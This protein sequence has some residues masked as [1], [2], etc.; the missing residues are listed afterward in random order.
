MCKHRRYPPPA[1]SRRCLFVASIR[2]VRKIIFESGRHATNKL[3][4]SCEKT[5]TG[6]RVRP[7]QQSTKPKM[8]R[9]II[10]TATVCTLPKK[11]FNPPPPAC[12]DLA[13]VCVTTVTTSNRPHVQG[14]SRRS[15]RDRSLGRLPLGRVPRARVG[16]GGPE[17]R[18]RRLYLHLG[19]R[20][21]RPAKPGGRPGPEGGAAGVRAGR[22]AG[23]LPL[24]GRLPR[25]A[26][27]GGGQEARQG[28]GGPEGGGRC[29]CGRGGEGY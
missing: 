7:A 2:H 11:L 15:V 28:G 26:L 14:R 4:G 17:A 24:P 29:N 27:E 12:G 6:T 13:L 18:Y 8:W 23:G 19:L 20:L 3:G 22:D 5:Y 25:E 1:R 10:E 9:E 16:I 21:R